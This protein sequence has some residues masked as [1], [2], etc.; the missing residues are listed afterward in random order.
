[1]AAF[2]CLLALAGCKDADVAADVSTTQVAV[3]ETTSPTTSTTVVEPPPDTTFAPPTTTQAVDETPEPEM[4]VAPPLRLVSAAAAVDAPTY[5]VTVKE[6]KPCHEDQPLRAVGDPCKD[7]IELLTAWS[8]AL[9]CQAGYSVLF[10]HVNEVFSEAINLKEGDVVT[11]HLA[12]DTL[13]V[14]QVEEWV[15][16]PG[17]EIVKTIARYWDKELDKVAVASELRSYAGDRSYGVLVFSYCRPVSATDDRC[18]N[19]DWYFH[20]GGW[21]RRFNGAVRIEWIGIYDPNALI[22]LP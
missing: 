14:G 10:G 16:G 6:D 9:P 13:C 22:E 15:G 3:V 8:S 19:E 12:D 2:L 7:T 18:R 1:M 4:P 11:A 5:V 21:H 17:E 20:D